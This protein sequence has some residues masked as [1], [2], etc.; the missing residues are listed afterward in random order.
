MM[1]AGTMSRKSNVVVWSSAASNPPTSR[2]ASQGAPTR[3]AAVTMTK[4]P[5]ESERRIDSTSSSSA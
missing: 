4:I 5:V 1:I 3:R 2:G